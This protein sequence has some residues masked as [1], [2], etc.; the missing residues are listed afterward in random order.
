[1]VAPSPEERDSAAISCGKTKSTAHRKPQRLKPGN[2]CS[3]YG[4]TEVVPFPKPGW[5]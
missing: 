4:T 3:S 2:D 5:R 1:M